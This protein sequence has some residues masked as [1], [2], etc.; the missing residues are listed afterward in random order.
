MVPVE[1]HEANGPKVSFVAR[2]LAFQ[3]SARTMLVLRAVDSPTPPRRTQ[4]VA[5]MQV[6]WL[7]HA[8]FLLQ[9]GDTTLLIDPFLSGSPTA[10]CKPDDVEP[11]VILQTHGHVDHY[12]DTV[13]IAKRCGATVV[14]IVEL[15]EEIKSKGVEDVRDPNLGGSVTFDWGWVKLMPAWHTGTTPDGA[16]HTP[17]GLLISF[18]GKLVYHLGDT[19]LFSD[20]ALAKRAGKIDLAIVP[21]GGHYTMDRHDAVAAVD[22][23]DPSQVLPC[24]YNT[25]PPI[26]TDA[27]AFQYDVDAQTNARCIVLDPGESHVV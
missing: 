27:A 10:S 2:F 12:L 17:A 3:E 25:F 5:L 1:R 24:H 19:A 11:D 14:A 20:L 8:T 26:E 23:V 16:V 4:E 22:L 15:A 21:I 7:G 13:E 18:G 9:D 6:T